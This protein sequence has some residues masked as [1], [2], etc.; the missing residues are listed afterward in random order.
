MFPNIKGPAFF[1]TDLGA[2]KNFAMRDR[3]NIQF[4][5]TAFNLVNHPLPQFGL[6]SDVN[7]FLN[8]TN[9]TNTNQATTGTPQFKVGRRVVELAIKYMF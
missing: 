7:L 8:G 1:D 6:G 3:Q 2:Y 4:R 9:G 5:L